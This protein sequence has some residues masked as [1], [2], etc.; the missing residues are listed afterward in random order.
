M[1]RLGQWIKT[2]PIRTAVVMVLAFIC[3][4]AAA[5]TVYVQTANVPIREEM[6]SLGQ[7]VV[8]VNRGAKLQVLEQHG[9]WL[10]VQFTDKEGKTYVGY[11]MATALS[12]KPVEDSAL[13]MLGSGGGDADAPSA[14]LAGKG[15]LAEAEQYATSKNLNP[16]YA[17]QMVEIRNSLTPEQL[18]A[19]QK[20]GRVGEA[21]VKK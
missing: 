17:N 5:E 7:E 14:A 15:L 4:A 11:C 1:N 12:P 9:A 10:K 8:R 2:R 18:R 20:A 16:A 13:D 21:Q 6:S 19:F 3:I